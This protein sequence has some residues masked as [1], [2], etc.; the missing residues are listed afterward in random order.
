MKKHSILRAGVLAAL[1]STSLAAN[2]YTSHTINGTD[3]GSGSTKTIALFADVDATFAAKV[4]LA[5]GRFTYKDAI[6][7]FKGAGV[8]P[9]KGAPV[10]AGET[11]GEIDNAEH[12]DVSF[13]KDIIIS[14]FRLGLLFDG[15][16]FKD[17]NEVAKITATYFDNS[18]HTFAFTANG[19]NTASW[20]GL[21]SYVNVSSATLGDAGVWDI[22]NPFGNNR[23]K[24]LS[25]G[26]LPGVVGTAGGAGTNQSDY[27]LISISAVP[28]PESYAMML[29]GLGLMGFVARRRKSV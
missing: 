7:G 1:I 28:E 12:I 3:L 4:G 26:V 27:S 24:T 14:S 20:T 15:P 18:V 17:V 22:I 6:D 21:G 9:T 5:E 29:A 13:S 10:V 11:P 23:I 25:F 8:S 16:E 19:L 2:A